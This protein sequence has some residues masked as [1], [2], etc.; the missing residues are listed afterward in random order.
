M[1]VSLPKADNSILLRETFF[2]KTEKGG[3]D[4]MGCYKESNYP[5]SDGDIARC[6]LVWENFTSDINLGR[7]SYINFDK[8]AP[9]TS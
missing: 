6:L 3:G 9:F 1:R 8:L 7:T 2:E 5:F 4:G